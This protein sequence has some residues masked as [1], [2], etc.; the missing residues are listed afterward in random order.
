MKDCY[1]RK[2]RWKT[3]LGTKKIRKNNFLEL[4]V[5]KMKSN[6]HAGIGGT[7]D[8]KTEMV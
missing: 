8:Q 3:I 5:R 1:G 7:K 2:K 6:V 4:Y